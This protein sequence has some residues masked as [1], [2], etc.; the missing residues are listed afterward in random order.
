MIEIPDRK[1]QNSFCFQLELGKRIR[2]VIKLSHFLVPEAVNNAAPA[3]IRR[4][5]HLGATAIDR[6]RAA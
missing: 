2:G 6:K 3:E 5:G 4:R 1:A